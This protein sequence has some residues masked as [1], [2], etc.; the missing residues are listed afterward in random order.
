[1]NK[2][3]LFIVEFGEPQN[4]YSTELSVYV[5]AQDYNEAANK[6]TL[7]AD[8]K[9]NEEDKVK[10]LFTDDGSLTNFA[11]TE[12]KPLQVKAVK[13]AGDVIW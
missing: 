7:Y 4:A 3:K 13:F 9:R 6:A 1:M 11:K 2:K 10:N 5:I 8:N 12:R